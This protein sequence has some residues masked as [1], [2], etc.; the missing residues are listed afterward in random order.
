MDYEYLIQGA[1]HRAAR[2]YPNS[3]DLELLSV[4]FGK[5]VTGVQFKANS[6]VVRCECS[7]FCRKR[8]S[9]APLLIEVILQNNEIVVDREAI[10]G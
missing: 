6:F 1:L 5:T 9:D 8:Q 10:T 2:P 7:E 4:L 3:L